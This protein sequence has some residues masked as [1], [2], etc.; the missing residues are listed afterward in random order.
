M[1]AAARIQTLLGFIEQ[2]PDDPF[3]RYALALEYKNAARLDEAWETFRELMARHPEYT[4]TYLHAGNVLVAQG[5][6][7]EARDTY[8]AG[9]LACQQRGDTHALGEL[10]GALASLG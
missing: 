5:R 1:S 9:V 3:P 8:Q 10:Q 4:A 7:Q 6:H 2:R